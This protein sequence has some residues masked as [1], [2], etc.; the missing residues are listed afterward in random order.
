MIDESKVT[1]ITKK[2]VTVWG[3][4]RFFL[5]WICMVLLWF[6]IPLFSAA[7][8][9]LMLSTI[10]IKRIDEGTYELEYG[11]IPLLRRWSNGKTHT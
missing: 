2:D 6:K 9:T 11:L 8:S 10:R 3:T 5:F 7:L 1:T 4:V